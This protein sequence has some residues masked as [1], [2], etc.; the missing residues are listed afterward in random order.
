[1]A[2]LTPATPEIYVENTREQI[3]VNKEVIDNII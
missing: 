3:K 1:M 2:E